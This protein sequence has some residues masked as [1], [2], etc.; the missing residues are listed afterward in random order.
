MHPRI[1]ET[2]IEIARHP[3]KYREADGTYSADIP[4]DLLTRMDEHSIPPT[5]TLTLSHDRRDWRLVTLLE[6]ADIWGEL[7]TDALR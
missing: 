1:R 7:R 5:T 2:L 6:P 4:A 3:D